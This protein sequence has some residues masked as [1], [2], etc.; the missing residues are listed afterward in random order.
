MNE[1]R[2]LTCNKNR[3]VNGK[4]LIKMKFKAKL[5][6]NYTKLQPRKRNSSWQKKN[7]MLF[8]QVC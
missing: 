1:Q 4:G 6:A 3:L 7:R 2:I 8:F 5:I